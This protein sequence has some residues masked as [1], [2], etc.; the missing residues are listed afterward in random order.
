MKRTTT[1]TRRHDAQMRRQAERAERAAADPWFGKRRSA[2]EMG[3]NK[4]RAAADKRA[5]R[6]KNWD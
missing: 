3:R 4:T 2:G 6:G 5:C 1:P